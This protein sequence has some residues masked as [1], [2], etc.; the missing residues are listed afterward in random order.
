M[1]TFLSLILAL[2]LPLAALAGNGSGNVSNVVGLIG[3]QS[4]TTV[5]PQVIASFGIPAGVSVFS[6]YA[7]DWTASVTSGNFYPFYKNGSAY[8]V[9]SGKTATC[10]NITMLINGSGSIQLM[11]A[12]AS[13]AFNAS[14]VT[15]GVYQGGASGRAVITNGSFTG[16]IPLTIPGTYQFTSLTYP[17]Y[18]VGSGSMD[19]PPLVHADCYE[20]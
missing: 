14:S 9:S 10:F 8:Q 20:Q 6:I 18:Q 4:A 3:A 1:K 2:F 7:G 17:G 5:A 11:S 12:T 13:F 16:G 15:G 19:R